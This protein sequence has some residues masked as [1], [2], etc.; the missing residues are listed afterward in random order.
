MREASVLGH[1]CTRFIAVI[2]LQI[3]SW[4]RQAANYIATTAAATHGNLAPNALGSS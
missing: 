2:D 4:L 3:V 1:T